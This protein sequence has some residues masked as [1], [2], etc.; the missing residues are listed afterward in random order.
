MLIYQCAK[1]LY[2]NRGINVNKE[3]E[4]IMLKYECALS[5]LETE[6]NILFKN[7]AYKREYNPVEHIK[8]RIKTKESAISKLEKKGYEFN[9]DNLVNNINDMI[10]V[11]VVCSFLT[12]VYEIVELIK[13]S[14][15]F[16]VKEEKDY[17]TNPKETGYM[18]Y[19][20][21]VMVPLSLDGKTEYL[22]AEIQVR[23]LAMDFWASLDHKI[24]YKFSGD[25]PNEVNEEM[26][27]CAM[28][29]KS[30]DDKMLRINKSMQNED[31]NEKSMKKI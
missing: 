22:E 25:I 2:K 23:T 7:N 15:S 8:S 24:K 13:K 27:K 1:K 16:T 20:L 17:I 9:I 26:Y 19:H 30:L 4:E 29:I 21:I 14:E 6:L 12:D 3:Y 11:R 10:G 5:L 18:S 31:S 28:D